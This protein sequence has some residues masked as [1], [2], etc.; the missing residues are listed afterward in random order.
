M[1]SSENKVI[2]ACAGSGKTTWLVKEALANRDRRIVFVTYTNNNTREIIKRFGELN[3]GVPR[4]VDVMTW[5]GFLLRECARPYQRSKYAEQRIESLLFVNEQSAKYIKETETKRHYFANGELIY[6]DKIA[7][8]VVE[9]ENKSGQRVIAR[10][11]QIY[12]DVFIDEFQDLAGWDLE[13]IGM[14]LQSRIRVTVVGD[15]RQHIYSTNPSSKNKQYLGIDIAKLLE[16]WKRNGLCTLEPMSGTHRCNAAICEFANALWPGMDAMKSLRNDTTDHDGVF[17]V[18]E[19]A[20]KGYIKRYSPQV[21][22]YD[23]RAE[24]YGCE[25]LNFGLAKGLEFGRVLIVPTSPIKKYLQSG[26][27]SHV[28][29]SRDKLHVAVTRARHSVAFV[30]DGQSPVVPKCFQ[31]KDVG[32]PY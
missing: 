13:L 11:H 17:L 22:R 16:I 29:A 31:P 8:F 19:N 15:P 12:T 32:L 21:L 24:T 18:A 4:H 25:A 28:E 9:C 27:L 23:K 20:V 30:Y 2:I 7:K 14:L 10:L 26:T 3:S 6:S 1:P 5:Y